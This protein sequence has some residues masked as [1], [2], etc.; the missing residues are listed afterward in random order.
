MKIIAFGAGDF[1][2]RYIT[3]YSGNDE[4]VAIADNF[5]DK[6]FIMGHK[7]IKPKEIL[8]YEF[9]RIVICLH[10]DTLKRHQIIDSVYTQLLSIGVPRK[11]II[12]NNMRED[13]KQMYIPRTIFMK[14][15]A[16][17]LNNVSGSMAECGVLRGNFAALINE[18][19]PTKKLLL[20]D[21][22]E[23]FDE[24]DMN[25]EADDE[26]RKWLTQ[27]NVEGHSLGSEQ[28]TLLRCPN[29]EMVK[30][31]KGYIPDTFEG[32]DSEKFCFVNLDMD[33]YAPTLHA[34]NYFAPLIEHGGIILLHDYF[35]ED[36][37]GIKRA[38]DE[39]KECLKD[40]VPFPI[41]DGYSLA[42][43]KI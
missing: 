31:Q 36:L 28:L 27:E 38:V 10:D 26:S 13:E 41:G 6:P 43:L 1:G 8:R 25:A 3:K 15:I 9:D 39:A 33:L 30:I 17:Q 14:N 21:T 18:L 7:V 20:F 23:G 40:F 22:F 32:L 34:L 12:L 4:I 5:C 11:K 42:L 37:P 35:C 24:R 19:M 16:K 29:Y 2:Y